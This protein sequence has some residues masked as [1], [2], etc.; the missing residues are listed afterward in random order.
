[1]KKAF[2]MALAC[3]LLT[4]CGGA[5]EPPESAT[6]EAIPQDTA[7]T[8]PEPAPVETDEA[9]AESPPEPISTA[10]AESL[11]A[12]APAEF[13][14][15]PAVVT[16]GQAPEKDYELPSVSTELGDWNQEE[17]PLA[18]LDQTEDM[19]LYGIAGEKDRI[20]LCWG[21]I[22]AEFPWSYRTPRAIPPQCWQI[23]VDGDGIEDAAIVCYCRSGTEVS[24]EQLHIVKK[25]SDGTLVD[26]CFPDE[27][28]KEQLSSQLSISVTGSQA[29]A[30]LGRELVDFSDSILELDL[31]TI[32]GIDTG[33]TANFEIQSDS[34]LSFYGN[35]RLM[36][37][38][39][40]VG[41]PVADITA[42]ISY[43]NGIFT[44]SDF[45]LNSI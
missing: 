37:A 40:A 7:D 30:I 31:S 26:A 22:E 3:L 27:L 21:D 42:A 29:F 15:A 5:G 4:G 28:W 16:V 8:L 10:P 24:V 18:L 45:H 9:A 19:A 17:E 43:K 44:L 39:Y 34:K 6:P 38:G 20:L 33:N 35:A 41:W 14:S 32:T 12:A 23:D 25:S 1:M 36:A 11:P 2:L 13:L